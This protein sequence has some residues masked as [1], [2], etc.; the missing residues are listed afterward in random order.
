[1]KE[2]TSASIDFDELAATCDLAGLGLSAAELHGQIVGLHCVCHTI[3]FDP[4]L[5]SVCQ[6]AELSQPLQSEDYQLL[7]KLYQQ[8]SGELNRADC[9]FQLLLPDDEFPLTQR[10][11]ALSQW[12]QGFLSGI[13]SAGVQDKQIQGEVKETIVDLIQ[14]A[15]IDT[16]SMDAED[17]DET[18]EKDY[19]EIIEYVRMAVLLLQ[20]E[21]MGGRVA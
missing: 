2:I 18:D 10:L 15:Q 11:A 5:V 1:M 12:T 4:W 19:A 6:D 7:K 3:E 8:T 13:A 9:G 14:I 20:T 17:T 21:W 16:A